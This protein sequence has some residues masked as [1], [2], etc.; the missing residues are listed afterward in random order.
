M[1]KYCKTF[2][3]FNEQ[4]YAYLVSWSNITPSTTVIHGE[5][6][7]LKAILCKSED[8]KNNILNL[9]VGE[10]YVN[11]K[12]QLNMFIKWIEKINSKDEY[13]YLYT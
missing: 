5:D 6:N 11:D 4:S 10:R 9:K 12:S 7:L 8:V 2:E 1:N 3:E 13:R